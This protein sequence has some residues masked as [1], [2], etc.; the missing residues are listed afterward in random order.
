MLRFINNRTW[1]RR[2]RRPFLLFI[3]L[4]NASVLF[5][6]ILTVEPAF[7]Q[8]SITKG[9]APKQNAQ[10]PPAAEAPTDEFGRDTPY[11]TVVGFLKAAEQSDWRRASEFLDSKR[12]P[13]QKQELA[14][15][16]KLVLD[17]GLA[18][19][20]KSISNNPLGSPTEKWR[21]TRNE[22]G[23]A[24]INDQ[25]LEILLDRITPTAKRPPY[26]LFSS[27][28]LAKV[29]ALAKNLEAPWF[30]IYIP[31]ALLENRLFGI[32]V[33]RL[34]EIP[35][36]I[37]IAFA[38]VWIVT[39]VLSFLASKIA[40]SAHLNPAL[41]KG[42]FLNPVRVLILGFLISGVAP[43]ANTLVERQRWH[44]LAIAVNIIGAAWLVTRLVD[45][46]GELAAGRFRRSNSLHRIAP[47]RL[48]CWAF[49]AVV[50]VAS[51]ALILY[52]EGIDL[53]TV[54][55]GL[56]LGGIALAF[57]AQKTIEN[58]FGTVMIVVD[59]P[60]R[61]GDYCKIGNSSGTI[62]EI[63]LRSTRIRT[64]DRTILTV[65]NGQL[66]SMILENCAPRERIWFHHFIGLRYETTAGQLRYL[67]VEF[68]RLFKNHP[69]V[70]SGSAQVRFIRFGNSSLDL[71]ISAYV[72][73]A[74]Y[75]TFLEVQE[76]L[77]LRIM[78]IVAEAGTCIAL[79]SQTTYLAKDHGLDF[80]KGHEVVE[81]AGKGQDR[82]AVS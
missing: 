3:T 56:G 81:E 25:S 72:L 44:E 71:E 2:C 49:K 62:E 38:F 30:E 53:S 8:I 57:A 35:L 45:L 47:M 46:S 40:Q 16:L 32:P 73:L 21:V 1:L 65:P 55:T 29:P 14:R 51:L 76:E 80:G 63:G 70:D 74:D 78:D 12:P 48:S 54:L 39:W 67:L 10:P 77:L 43:L 82:V 60:V 42:G 69:K 9:M 52:A 36:I 28:T 79:P 15:Q 33:F 64:L 66:A 17:R 24:R 59:Q 37:I 34:I 58:V 68:R 4:L 50:L 7:G 61:V 31:K 23:T 13:K 22:I 27:E 26:W 41:S 6:S 19:D 20:L 75:G 11:G 18:L 5:L